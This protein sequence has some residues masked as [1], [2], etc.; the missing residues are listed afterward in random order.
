MTEIIAE[1]IATV[2]AHAPVWGFVIIF[3]LM[4][5][6]SSFLFQVKW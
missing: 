3:L 1:N 4:A 2:A 5:I 6:E